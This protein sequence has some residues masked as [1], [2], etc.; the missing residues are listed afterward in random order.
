MKKFITECMLLYER[1]RTIAMIFDFDDEKWE[2]VYMEV[3][4]TECDFCG[5]TYPQGELYNLK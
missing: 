4:L 2:Q 1:V 5:T 3:I